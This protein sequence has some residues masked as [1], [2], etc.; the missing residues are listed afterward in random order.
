MKTKVDEW[1]TEY[2]TTDHKMIDGLKEHME[3]AQEKIITLQNEI[4]N[5]RIITKKIKEEI[6][7]LEVK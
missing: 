1:K 3:L 2:T 5:W 4:K 7:K 6:K